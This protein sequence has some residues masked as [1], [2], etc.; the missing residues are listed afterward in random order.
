MINS[1]SDVKARYFSIAVSPKNKLALFYS[2]SVLTLINL[3]PVFGVIVSP[4][5]IIQ[6]FMKEGDRFVPGSDTSV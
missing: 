4:A 2:G 6:V 1:G 3:I 5:L